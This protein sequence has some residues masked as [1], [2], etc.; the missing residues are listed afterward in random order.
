MSNT[1]DYTAA[2]WTEIISAPYIVAAV[3]S[4]A[5]HGR[6][7]REAE[8][9]EL[10]ALRTYLGDLPDDLSAIFGL[11]INPTEAFDTYVD[12]VEGAINIVERITKR[13]ELRASKNFNMR[14]PEVVGMAYN[15]SAMMMGNSISKKRLLRPE[16]PAVDKDIK[17]LTTLRNSEA[18]PLGLLGP[19]G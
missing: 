6:N 13:D 12:R 16:N 14:G 5:N 17:T 1:A 19:Q 10:D 7:R 15:G 4:A 3:N 18:G 8:D 9:I 11:A 2:E